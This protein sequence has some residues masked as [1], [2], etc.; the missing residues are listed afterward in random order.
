MVLVSIVLTYYTYFIST[1]IFIV[2]KSKKVT[3]VKRRNIKGK[4]VITAPIRTDRMY[5]VFYCTAVHATPPVTEGIPLH[6]RHSLVKRPRARITAAL[7]CASVNPNPTRDVTSERHS[8]SGDRRCVGVL[9]NLQQQSVSVG[10]VPKHTRTWERLARSSS[11]A[12]LSVSF[13]RNITN[14]RVDRFIVKYHQLQL[15]NET[16]TA[17]LLE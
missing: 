4:H 9:A 8:V 11:C 5:I 13:T 16:L 2:A 14:T 15:D 6:F 12:P 17:R 7:R 1:G 3:L 10:S